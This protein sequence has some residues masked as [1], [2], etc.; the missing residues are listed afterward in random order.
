MPI[1]RA[2]I[3]EGLFQVSGEI[4]VKQ[5]HPLPPVRSFYG[6]AR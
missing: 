6:V 3:L 2:K 4:I 5:E 1:I